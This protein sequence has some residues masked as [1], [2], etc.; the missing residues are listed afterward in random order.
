MDQLIRESGK[1]AMCMQQVEF[2]DQP[3]TAFLGTTQGGLARSSSITRWIGSP[4]EGSRISGQYYASSNA[5][6]DV[7]VLTEFE[8]L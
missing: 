3:D 2:V 4:L 6:V 8:L 7:V 1:I 5:A